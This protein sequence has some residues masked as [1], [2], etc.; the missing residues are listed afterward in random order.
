MRL[1]VRPGNPCVRAFSWAVRW[2]P[3]GGK[4][5]HFSSRLPPSPSKSIPGEQAVNEK[6]ELSKD[7]RPASAH[8]VAL[9][10]RVAH[11]PGIS[12]WF[13]FDRRGTSAL[14]RTDFPYLLGAAH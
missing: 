3:Y 7:H 5:P 8:N 9:P 13:P 12:T 1:L 11:G 14:F 2:A 6:R 10:Q 4:I